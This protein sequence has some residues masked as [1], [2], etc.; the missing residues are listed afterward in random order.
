[1]PTPD[2]PQLN[3]KGL[4]ALVAGGASFLGS[5][6]CETLLSQNIQVLAVDNLSHGNRENIK[7]LLTNPHFSFLEYDLNAPSSRISDETKIDYIFHVAGVEEKIGEKDLSLETLLVNSL[8]TKNLL[9]LARVHKA[10]FL[11]VSSTDIYSG[12]LSSQSLNYYFGTSKKEE[13]ILTHHEAKRY[14]EALTFEYFKKYNVDA[15]I[16][17]IQDVYGPRINL[18]TGETLNQL[19]YDALT[20]DKVTIVGDGLKI[21]HPTYISDVVYGL[22]KAVLHEDTKGKIFNLINPQ[23]ITVLALVNEFKNAFAK[24]FDLHFVKEEGVVDFGYHPLDLDTTIITLG[25]KP[26]VPLIEGLIKTAESFK[27]ELIP[28]ALPVSSSPLKSPQRKFKWPT[29]ILPSFW[30]KKKI[31]PTSQKVL[32]R[33]NLRFTIFLASL[34][35][36]LLGVFYPLL[37]F[38]FSLNSGQE[39]LRS[40][41]VQIGSADF[42]KAQVFAH[43]AASSWE[44]A[45]QDLNNL[46]WLATILHMRATSST[47][48]ATLFGLESVAQGVTLTSSALN[49][50]EE[51]VTNFKNPQDSF[52]LSFEQSLNSQGIHLS[53]AQ[54]KF[55]VAEATF[56]ELDGR[57][58]KSFLN[59]EKVEVQKSLAQNKELLASL[60]ELYALLPDFL[61]FKTSKN[62]LLLEVDDSTSRSSGGVLKNY[63][64][65][66]LEKGIVKKQAAGGLESL[67]NQNTTKISVPQELK[68]VIKKDSLLLSESLWEVGIGEGSLNLRRF[69]VSQ[70]EPLSGVGVI[71]STQLSKLLPEEVKLDTF[72]EQLKNLNSEKWPPLLTALRVGLE[73]KKAVFYGV[74]EPLKSILSE[75]KWSGEVLNEKLLSQK[76]LL[77][78]Q[79]SIPQDVIPDYL[80]VVSDSFTPNTKVEPKVDYLLEV[81]TLGLMDSTVTLSYE[82]SSDGEVTGYT[83]VLVPLGSVLETKEVDGKNILVEQKSNKTQ[84]GFPLKIGSGEKKQV[85]LKYQIPMQ[86]RDAKQTSYSMLLQKPLG[87]ESVKYTINMVFPPNIII[88]PNNE[89][90]INNQKISTSIELLQDKLF[91]LKFKKS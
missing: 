40:A 13:K 55:S 57:G 14:A 54:D 26:R 74:E 66:T 27:K 16:C 80:F 1:M 73:D 48:D 52:A 77:R 49:P 9:D 59:K 39:A 41:L 2:T 87:V 23:K 75:A 11:L 50:M 17:R 71:T 61:G 30:G 38:F 51:L 58:Q 7:Y 22:V 10:K 42:G 24:S 85:I 81:G 84:F 4:T 76:A 72:V 88:S 29:L 19:I 78:E 62:Y 28:A 3:S 60:R 33:K 35:L 69:F 89:F 45:R 36:L 67:N 12:A 44:R 65:V 63:L 43:R 31:K 82:N 25:W 56:M 20:S 46:N 5:H 83:R 15:R 68:E 21:L 70:G 86:I 47:L 91:T 8:G 64:L 18:E 37:S 32:N 79:T 53:L 34:L 90:T 6:L